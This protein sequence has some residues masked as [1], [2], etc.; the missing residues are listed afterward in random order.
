MFVNREKS[1]WTQ[2]NSKFKKKMYV[3]IFTGEL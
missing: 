1:K 2:T 3:T